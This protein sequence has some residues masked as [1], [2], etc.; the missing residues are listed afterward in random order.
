MK[1]IVTLITCCGIFLLTLV[2]QKELP[3][4]TVET[5][6]GEAIDIRSVLG[7][8]IPVVLSFWG[9]TC[10]P[11][12]ME[13]DA[14]T[15]VYDD[16]Q[17]EVKFKVVA[18]ATDD[19]RAASKVKAMAG[20]RGWPFEVILDKNQGLKRAMNVNSIPFLYVMDKKGKIVYTHAGYTPGSELQVLNVLKKLK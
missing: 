3:K 14:L 20:G 13:L 1:K 18:V 10:K 8:S 6:K 11:C 16:W 12:L 7:D 15:E 5:L 4:V 19:S 17:E 9:T 2:S